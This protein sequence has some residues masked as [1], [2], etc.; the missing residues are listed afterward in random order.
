MT[1]IT[2]QLSNLLTQR[3][4]KIVANYACKVFVV[5]V[6]LMPD[7]GLWT[8][9]DK[10][11]APTWPS[12][13]KCGYWTRGLGFDSRVGQSM[14]VLLWLFENFSVVARNLELC[15]VYDNRL[16]TYNMRL[17]IAA[18]RAAMCTSAYPFVTYFGVVMLH[19]ISSESLGN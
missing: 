3:V 8:T 7:Q 11:I 1:V 18:L 16:T 12:G 15:P 9:K 6:E 4:M 5:P 2:S 14:T 17:C 13:R 19:V 10:K